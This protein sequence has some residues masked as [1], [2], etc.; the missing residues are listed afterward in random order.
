MEAGGLDDWLN[1][2]PLGALAAITFALMFVAAAVGRALRARQDRLP[3]ALKAQASS[4]DEYVIT[5]VL[6][7][8]ALLLGFTFALAIDRFETRRT[9]V[10]DDANAIRTAWLQA[11]LLD[12]PHRSR[13]SGTL[14]AYTDNRISLARAAPGGAGRAMLA[15]NDQL[16]ADL[17]RET[18]DAFPTIKDLDFSG[19]FL[20]RIEAVIE[21]D[22][23]RK[24]ERL[25]HV[26]AAVFFVLFVY[27]IVTAGVLGYVLTGA[28]GRGVA[29]F[30][31]VLLMLSLVLIIDIDRPTRGVIQEDQ[32]PMELLRRELRSRQ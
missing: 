19:L 9:L 20:E 29:A 16:I 26:P 6:G 11:Q 14:E 18:S 17:W 21:L 22:A 28:R 1:A 30:V 24:F 7:L 10:L 31:L 8:L 32:A 13:I 25:S 23:A 27:L 5:S 3:D 15:E 12:E 2:T 4:Q